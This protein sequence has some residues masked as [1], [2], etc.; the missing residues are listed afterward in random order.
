MSAELGFEIFDKEMK[1]CRT[2]CVLYFGFA[3]LN[4]LLGEGGKNRI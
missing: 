1:E 3:D 4:M 2:I